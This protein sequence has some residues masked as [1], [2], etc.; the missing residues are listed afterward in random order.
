MA[1]IANGR[2]APAKRRNKNLNR[3]GYASRVACASTSRDLTRLAATREKP[4]KRYQAIAERLAWVL[5]FAPAILLAVNLLTDHAGSDPVAAIIADTGDWSLRLLWLSLAIT[6]IRGLSGWQWLGPLRRDFGLLSFFY[7]CLHVAAYT[8]F[9][10]ELDFAEIW[11][12]AWASGYVAVGW[13]TFMLFVP[14]ALTSREAAIKRIGGRTWRRLHKLV[15]LCAICGALHFLLL[16]KRDIS[17][18]GIYALILCLL[19]YLRLPGVTK[20]LREALKAR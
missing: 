4:E 11:N 9:E 19:F 18:P 8:I 1:T 2:H 13:I 16:T 20:K 5:G 15:Y 10:W 14:L 17:E 12:A 3:V 7:A 6:P